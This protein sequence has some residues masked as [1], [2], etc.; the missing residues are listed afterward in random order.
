MATRLHS[1]RKFQRYAWLRLV[2]DLDSDSQLLTVT[3]RSRLVRLLRRLPVLDIAPLHHVQHAMGRLEELAGF[4]HQS[5]RGTAQITEQGGSGAG[6]LYDRLSTRSEPVNDIL[7][8]AANPLAEGENPNAVKQRADEDIRAALSDILG[9]GGLGTNQG[10][11]GSGDRGAEA[12]HAQRDR[13][14]EAEEAN[15]EA[16]QISKTDLDDAGQDAMFLI[17]VETRV[18]FYE[19]R[20]KRWSF[21]SV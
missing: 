5:G 18:R 8:R 12:H 7:E 20:T 21:L 1:T 9:G 3:L 2:T 10:A 6:E 11:E 4:C 15:P 14:A 19:E 16:R 17:M 13:Q